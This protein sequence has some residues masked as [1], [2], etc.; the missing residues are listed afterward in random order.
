MKQKRTLLVL[1]LAVLVMGLV[2][3][4]AL[5]FSSPPVPRECQACNNNKDCGA[6]QSGMHCEDGFCAFPNQGCP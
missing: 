4:A 6:P 2:G 1:V 3:S 5:T